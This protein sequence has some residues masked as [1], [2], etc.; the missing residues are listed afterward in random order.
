MSKVKTKTNKTFQ[1]QIPHKIIRS[2]KMDCTTFFVYAKLVQLYRW[3][4]SKSEVLAFGHTNFKYYTNIKSNQKLKKSLNKLY[5]M[6]LIR[7]KV[8]ELPRNQLLEIEINPFFDLNKVG[9]EKEDRFSYTQLP[10]I[11]LD[12]CMIDEIGH[13]G[14]RLLYYY[15]SYTNRKKTFPFCFTSMRTI[16]K[17]TGLSEN[18]IIRYNKILE[19]NKLIDIKRH[20]LEM[21]GYIEDEFGNERAYFQR[22]NNH[23]RVNIERIYTLHEKLSQKNKI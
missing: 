4:G 7:T 21:D 14:V 1:I 2:S 10:Y 3:R 13:T 6:K 11:L 15:E 20:K 12:K 8:D 18:T 22:Y 23:Y 19:K 5:E 16:Q 9:K 17:E